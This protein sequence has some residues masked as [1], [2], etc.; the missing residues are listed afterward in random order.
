ME[1]RSLTKSDSRLLLSLNAIAHALFIPNGAIT[2]ILGPLLPLLSARWGLNDTRAGY[3][4]TAQFVGCLFATLASGEVLPQL[5]F[6]WTMVIGLAFMTFG[7]GT[8]DRKSTR[9]NS[10][11]RL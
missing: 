7:T 8:L 2:V 9:L 6:R 10:S 3:L 1:V 11:H 5:G 4:V